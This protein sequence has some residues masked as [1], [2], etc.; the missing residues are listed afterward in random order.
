MLNKASPLE[1][2]VGTILVDGF[3]R[4]GRGL[5][6]DVLAELRHPNALGLQV[7]R[8]LPLDGFSNVTPDAAFFLCQTGTVNFPSDSY[9]G[10]ANAT[11]SRHRSKN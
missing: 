1:C 3:E 5:H 8:H 4:Y 2:R 9:L 10:S 6:F 11:N 7:R